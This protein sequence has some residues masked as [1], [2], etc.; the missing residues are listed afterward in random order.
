M[1]YSPINYVLNPNKI[2]TKSYLTQVV[3]N[4]LAKPENPFTVVKED[5]SDVYPW[6]CIVTIGV[7]GCSVI[8]SLI[9][10]IF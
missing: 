10:F 8:Y 2:E 5:T 1:S 3:D 6:T 4:R 9:N 7:V